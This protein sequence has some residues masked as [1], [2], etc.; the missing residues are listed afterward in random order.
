MIQDGLSGVLIPIIIVT[1][2]FVPHAIIYILVAVM[3]K[4]YV[5]VWNGSGQEI[6]QHAS[7]TGMIQLPQG[8]KL[9][10]A[11]CLVAQTQFSTG[12]R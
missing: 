10:L 11:Y 1:Q 12:F 7:A 5:V 6:L 8:S 9:H 4:T 3:C 2:L